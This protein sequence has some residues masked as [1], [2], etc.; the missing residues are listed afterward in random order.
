MKP[1]R[2]IVMTLTIFCLMVAGLNAQVVR[3]DAIKAY[4]EGVAA[5]DTD[6]PAAIK[7]FEKAIEIA[8]Q[9]GAEADDIKQ[10][11]MKIVPSLYVKVANKAVSDKAP[12]ADI[13]RLSKA[14]AAVAAK[15]NNQT[16]KENSGKL[17]IQGYNAMANDFFSKNDYANALLTFDS[18]LAVNPNYSNA[19]FN[20]ALAYNKMNDDANFESAIDLYIE[21]MK[22]VND[23]V[24]IAKASKMALEYFRQAGSK[25]NQGNKL[26]D[27]I[28]LLDKAAKY[29]NDKDVF[30]YYA[31]VYNK[32]KNFDKGM[33]FAQ[34]GLDLETGTPE[35]KAKFYYQLGV[36]QEGKGLKDDACATFKNSMFGPFTDAS[37]AHRTNLKCAD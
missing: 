14:A 11:S 3:N 7:A 32:Q 24:K 25:A 30:Y 20:K 33:E 15:Y 28:A 35:A 26:A 16:A 8:G 29:G 19:I 31:D 18:I 4:N 22:G 27:A 5:K 2:N 6:I 9:V 34:K 1:M 10:N 21:K 17:M 13:L 37:K 23:T 12:A 36:A